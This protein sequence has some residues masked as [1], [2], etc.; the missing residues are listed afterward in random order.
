M[1]LS[2]LVYSCASVLLGYMSLFSHSV[3]IVVWVS[4]I[5]ISFSELRS[6]WAPQ[7]HSEGPH[8]EG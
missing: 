1:V 3:N 4:I 2:S 7:V 5:K 6:W 8:E